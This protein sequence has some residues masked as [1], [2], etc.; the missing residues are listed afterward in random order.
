MKS[1]ETQIQELQQAIAAFESQRA[2]LG[3]AAID[4]AVAGLR[5]KLQALS[6]S[7][8]EAAPLVG[9]LQYIEQVGLIQL[10]KLEPELEYLFRHALVQDAAYYSLLKQDRRHMHRQVAR[11]LER[12]YLDRREELAPALA[13]HFL[14]AGDD[15]KAIEYSRLAA[16]LAMA[17][18]ANGEA[19]AH[20]RA[21]LTLAAPGPGRAAL[22]DGLGRAVHRQGRFAEAT[23]L[24]REAITLYR[25]EHDFNHAARLYARI[26]RT[27]WQA[28]DVR[29][30]LDVALEGLAALDGAPAS[31]GMAAL[32]NEAGR[33]A[34]FN[35]RVEDALDYC[36]RA[37]AMIQAQGSGEVEADTLITWGLLPQ[38]PDEDRL[39]A[40]RRAA[41]MAEAN[42]WLQV[43]H[44]ALNNLG[45]MVFV[46]LDDLRGA[47]EYYRRAMQ[48]ARR[49]GATVDEAW[50]MGNLIACTISLGELHATEALL[51][52]LRQR[53]TVLGHQ[54]GVEAEY[55]SWRAWFHR[56]R[57]EWEQALQVEDLLPQLEAAGD[58]QILSRLYSG[59]ADMWL[60]RGNL[61]EAERR[62]R[63]ALDVFDLGGRGNRVAVCAQLAAALARQG[64]HDEADQVLAEAVHIA[65]EP[66]LPASERGL[67][68]TS[69][70]VAAARGDWQAALEAYQRATELQA[71]GGHLWLRAQTLCE[72]A[73]VCAQRGEEGDRQRASA[74][75]RDAQAQLETMGAPRY[76]EMIGARLAALEGR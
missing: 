24:W 70:Q 64:R 72:M 34:Y 23:R 16:E 10:A 37:L 28:G 48:V 4:A 74:L 1:V 35:G 22:L 32:L 56:C 15:A 42:G 66:P 47:R 12:L 71:R 33:A 5:Q 45:V 40:L 63:Q 68:L 31:E 53:L 41:D 65:G 69:G 43:A 18:F 11:T 57:A 26:G 30:N 6:G 21:A 14:E 38:P 39:D 46:Q 51:D 52:D 44:R 75:L 61:V 60:E 19:E 9:Q 54:P 13:H 2:T 50:T 7:S 36:Q 20:Y 73:E 67:A 59:L 17:R 58:L 76:V 25:A 8:G 49:R 29:S 3:D 55:L 62:I 27:A